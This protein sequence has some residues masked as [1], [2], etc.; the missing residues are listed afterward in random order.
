MFFY[1]F[2]DAGAAVGQVIIMEKTTH[3]CII[4]TSDDDPHTGLTSPR[5]LDSWKT[6]L[7]AARLRQHQ[8]LLKVAENLPDGDVPAVYYHLKCRKLF[9]MK[10]DLEKL[11]TEQPEEVYAK[12]RSQRQLPSSS[13]TV[14]ERNCIFCPVGRLCK[15][16]KGTHTREK[17][18]QCVEL[19][20]DATLRDIATKRQDQRILAILTRDIVAAEAW[21]HRSCYRLYT[22]TKD[23]EDLHHDDNKVDDS[24]DHYKQVEA[25]SYEQLFLYIKQE[26][27]ER[28]EVVTLVSLTLRLVT[29]MNSQGVALVR[30]SP[31][32]HIR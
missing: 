31:R 30:D 16:I 23:F 32:K 26:F 15:Y 20:A 5:D 17:L 11:D 12:R 10:R 1:I 21:Y 14:M 22:N 2:S 7:R 25:A 3:T 27:F 6:L 4:H 19:R 9:T 24:D 28:P 18:T 13:S 8:P 29:Y